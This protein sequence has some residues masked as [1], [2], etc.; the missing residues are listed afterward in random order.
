[1]S[2]YYDLGRQAAL[3]KVGIFAAA[4]QVAAPHIARAGE[5]IRSGLTKAKDK[6]SPAVESV[7]DKARQAAGEAKRKVVEAPPVAHAVGAGAAAGTGAGLIAGS[8]ARPSA[9]PATPKVA[10]SNIAGPH[11]YHR[12]PPPQNLGIEDA[13]E[14]HV[15]S[16]FKSLV[17]LAKRALS[18]DMKVASGMQ[19][20]TASP[21][22]LNYYRQL[23][24]M[25]GNPIPEDE[26]ILQRNLYS[27]A[28]HP[29]LNTALV[30]HL[31]SQGY[32]AENLPSGQVEIPEQ[33]KQR[34]PHLDSAGFSGNQFYTSYK[35]D[36][37]VPG[38]NAAPAEAPAAATQPAQQPEP[39]PEPMPAKPPQQPA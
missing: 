32:S 31:K 22:V 5:A 27:A 34:F 11:P 37:D 15:P 30:N 29:F 17:G 35:Q 3:E 36:Y 25:Q 21:E 18:S 23:E 20:F 14:E 7:R 28:A 26:S 19:P 9:P 13:L 6:M 10:A 38:L 39:A 2:I 33:I 1:M 24:E 8:A 4:R 12:R 16:R